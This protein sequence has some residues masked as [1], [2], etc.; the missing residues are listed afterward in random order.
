MT[1]RTVPIFLESHNI[2][3]PGAS[4]RKG[5]LRESRTQR[6]RYSTKTTCRHVGWPDQIQNFRGFSART[7]PP[8]KPLI[9][10]DSA[11]KSAPWFL[12]FSLP[13]DFRS[14]TTAC[15]GPNADTGTNHAEGAELMLESA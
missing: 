8:T 11:H 10:S 2:L 9:H 1:R 7:R 13:C 5:A 6:R 15:G 12:G 14:L 3:I 4:I